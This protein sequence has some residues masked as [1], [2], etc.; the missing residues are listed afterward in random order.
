M[1]FSLLLKLPNQIKQKIECFTIRLDSKLYYQ[2]IIL[3]I[4]KSAYLKDYKF[5]L[6]PFENCVRKK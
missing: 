6:V 4:M 5:S 2:I 3:I 1:N